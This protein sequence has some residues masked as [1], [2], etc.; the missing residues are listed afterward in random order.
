M[1]AWGEE[2][3]KTTRRRRKRRRRRRR[4]RLSLFQHESGYVTRSR[5]DKDTAADYAERGMHLQ[6][7]IVF[8]IAF[9]IVIVAAVVM[10][11]ASLS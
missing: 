9:V 5:H 11:A 8:A 10:N 6:A 3:R 4:R 1:P 2:V 7:P